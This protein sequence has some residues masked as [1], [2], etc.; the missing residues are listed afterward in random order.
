[1]LS[2]WYLEKSGT[3]GNCVL[4]GEWYNPRV[5]V[6]KNSAVADMLAKRLH[7]RIHQRP[8]YNCENNVS[9]TFDVLNEGDPL[10]LSG[11]NLVWEN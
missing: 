11:S 8:L 7:N 10:E 4:S 9:P 2:G 5:D 1:M 6:Y 3:L